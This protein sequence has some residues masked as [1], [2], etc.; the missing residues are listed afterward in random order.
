MRQLLKSILEPSDFDLSPKQFVE[1][2]CADPPPGVRAHRTGASVECRKAK[3]SDPF[4]GEKWVYEIWQDMPQASCEQKLGEEDR[5]CTSPQ[6]AWVMAAFS[7]LEFELEMKQDR[8]KEKTWSSI[9]ECQKE[10]A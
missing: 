7:V 6:V 1:K 9:A 3:V 8:L 10:P 5:S 2:Y 4:C